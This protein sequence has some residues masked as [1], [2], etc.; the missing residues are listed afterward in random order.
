MSVD[1]SGVRDRRPASYGR[2]RLTLDIERLLDITARQAV[3]AE[4]RFD[5]ARSPFTVC[6]DLVVDGGPRVRWHIGRD[7]LEQGLHSMSGL[8]D[9]K[10]WPSNRAGRDTAWLRLASGDMA[11]LFELPAAPLARWL[12]R[13]YE[14]VPAGAEL[15]GVDWDAAAARVL[16]GPEA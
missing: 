7:L 12:E 8:G 16:G 6:L 15:A 14:A 1:K 4:F 13:V 2:S 5:A 9:V 10:M 11:A 3:R